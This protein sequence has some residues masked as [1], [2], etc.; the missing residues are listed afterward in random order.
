MSPIRADGS[1][2]HEDDEEPTLEP[3]TAQ[4][5]FAPRQP[6]SGERTPKASEM[7]AR[8]PEDPVDASSDPRLSAMREL[9]AAGDIAEALLIAQSINPQSPWSSPADGEPE[10][11]SRTIAAQATTENLA[12]LTSERILVLIRHP[13]E[14]AHL[15]VD[16]RAGFL[17]GHIDGKSTMEEIL[18][19]CAMPESE[20]I[21]I[22]RRLLSMGVIALKS[23]KAKQPPRRLL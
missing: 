5:G 21:L 9:Y 23:A 2:G 20:A 22:I 3:P 12:V 8:L 13:R 18:D 6:E 14:I 16:H 17:L 1:P 10:P 15:S 11:C 4:S 7:R 19:V